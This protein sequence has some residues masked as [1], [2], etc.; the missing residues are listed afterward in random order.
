M[1]KQEA[2]LPDAGFAGGSA[3]AQV[4]WSS[5]IYFVCSEDVQEVRRMRD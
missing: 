1:G 5:L 3:R 4:C 2:Y